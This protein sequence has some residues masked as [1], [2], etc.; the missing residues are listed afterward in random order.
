MTLD[1][2]TEQI[3]LKATH[4]DGLDATIKIA[5]DQGAIFIDGKQ[6]PAVVSNEDIPADTTIQ[7]TV[8]NLIKMGTGDLNPMMAFMMGK[9]KVQGDMGVAMKVGQIMG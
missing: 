3:R 8:E 1:Q 4:A 7:I 9:I 2:I 5:T 6:S